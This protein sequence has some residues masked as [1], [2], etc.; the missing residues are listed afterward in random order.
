MEDD[1]VTINVEIVEVGPRDGLQN[2]ANTLPPATRQEFILR[3]ARA[4][5]RRVE[6]VSFVNPKR[7]PQMANAEEVLEGLPHSREVSISGLVLN[8]RGVERAISSGI[9][10]INFVVVSTD[11]FSLRNQGRTTI[12]S[13]DEWKAVAEIA[14][15][16]GIRY[17]VTLA[18]A[19]GC[20]FEGR[21]AI[22]SVVELARLLV[23]E[24]PFELVIAD[25]IG[26]AVPSA[27]A[28]ML[29]SLRTEIRGATLRCHFH[30]TRNAGYSNVLAAIEAGVRVF[31]ASLGGIGGCPFAPNATGNVCTE[32]LA[33]IL[34]EMGMQT[35]IDLHGAIETSRWIC[36]ELGI[37]S[38]GLISRAGPFPN[39]PLDP[40]TA[41]TD[42]VV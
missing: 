36:N 23:S 1:L 14:R 9:D 25:T 3:A 19:F 4:G 30:N 2:E 5:L 34:G 28:A 10:E 38:P 22:E 32:D 17:S 42:A 11:T 16:A 37:I 29:E 27:V 15:S 26:A 12:Q 13:V 18:A 33:W 24:D 31:D 20:P 35:G 7:V 8:R 40:S 21:V 39:L 41:P 6:G